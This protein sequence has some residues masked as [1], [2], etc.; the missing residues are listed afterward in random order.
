MRGKY[1]RLTDLYVRGTE[2]ELADGN[3]IWMQALNPYEREEALHDAQVARARLVMALKESGE[4]R[5]KVEAH[6]YER[7][8]TKCVEELA[9][10]KASERMGEYMADINSDPDW[11]ERLEILMRTDEAQAATPMEPAEQALLTKINIDYMAELNKRETDEREYQERRLA[12]MSQEVFTEEY[13]EWWLDRRGS[14]LAQAEFQT[15]ELWFSARVCDAVKDDEGHYSHE[16]CNHGERVFEDKAEVRSLPAELSVIL[17]TALNAITMSA[18]EAKNSAR[19]ESSSDSS[20]L[21]SEPVES[22]PSI[23]TE[24]LET[25]PG[26]SPLQ[27]S[28]A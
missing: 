25:V 7:G 17:N 6:I 18:V 27:S 24:T 13:L 1:K 4:E 5:L 8:L 20:P 28:T 2:A 26:T 22:T 15:T 23:Q 14:N 19:Q 10:N 21:P 12:G 11:K 16:A 3:I 9:R